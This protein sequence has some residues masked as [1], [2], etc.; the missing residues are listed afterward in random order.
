[1]TSTGKELFQIQMLM[2]QCVSSINLSQCSEEHYST[3]NPIMR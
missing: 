3:Q 2:R 1:M